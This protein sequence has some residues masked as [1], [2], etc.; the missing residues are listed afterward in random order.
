[1]Y[2]LYIYISMEYSTHIQN[3]SPFVFIQVISHINHTHPHTH[4]LRLGEN[5]KLWSILNC[6]EQEILFFLK[7]QK[8]LMLPKAILLFCSIFKIQSVRTQ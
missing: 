2:I 1:M 7:L 4:T 5:F 6:L 3:A 8:S